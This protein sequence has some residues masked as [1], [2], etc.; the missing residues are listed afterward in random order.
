MLY[1]DEIKDCISNSIQGFNSCIILCGPNN[2]GKS[3]TLRG[4]EHHEGILGKSVKDL[5]SLMEIS[6]QV[7]TGN[8][9]KSLYGLKMSIYTV[10]NECIYD[11][12]KKNSSTPLQ[13]SKFIDKDTGTYFTKINDLSEAEIKNYNEYNNLVNHS[14][15]HRKIL[16][17]T[18]K[19]NDFKKKSNLIVSFILSKKEISAESN[20]T[21]FEKSQN[22]AQIDFVE[23]TSTDYGLDLNTD[24]SDYFGKTT[25]TNF[26]SIKNNLESLAVRKKPRYESNLTLA[27]KRTLNPTSQ[28]VFI[29]CVHS[30]EEPPTESY[31]ALKVKNFILLYTLLFI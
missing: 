30:N 9:V 27:L 21:T 22:I 23:L 29:N 24:K 13:I 28:I 1:N 6:Q 12:V 15:Q 4:E 25:A 16:E 17:T 31:K 8:T 19:V 11:L 18:L 10:F 7:N 20:S 14:L 3:Y 26:R 2:A 5:F